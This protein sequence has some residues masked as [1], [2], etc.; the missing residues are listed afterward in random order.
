MATTSNQHY[1]LVSA[2]R[3]SKGRYPSGNETY[4]QVA[5]WLL[6]MSIVVAYQWFSQAYTLPFGG[7]SDEPAHYVTSLMVRDYIR[8]G[9]PQSPLA[10]A[11]QFYVH[12]PAVAFGMWGPML[13]VIGGAWMAIFSA[14][15]L[16]IMLLIATLSATFAWSAQWVSRRTFGSLAGLLVGLGVCLIP[17]FQA[18]STM[19]MADILTGTFM[20][21]AAY[22]WSRYLENGRLSTS[23]GFGVLAGLALL[24]KANAGALALMPLPATLL[25]RRSDLLRRRSFWIPPGIVAVLAGPW[26]I[27]YASL[28]AH[29]TRVPTTPS[30]VYRYLLHSFGIFGVLT[31]PFVLA[32]MGGL[33][34]G[35]G[36]APGGRPLWAVSVS[37]LLGFILYHCLVP[38]GFESRYVLMIAPWVAV[39][40]ISGAALSGLRLPVFIRSGFP[41]VLLASVVV[42]GAATIRIPVKTQLPYSQV[43]A[44][45]VGRTNLPQSVF[46]FS[47]E[48]AVETAFVA[49]VA[50]RDKRP[51]HFVLRGSKML[52][53][54]NWNG[55]RYENRA[56]DETQV[57]ERLGA[58]G[59]SRVIIDTTPGATPWPHHRLLR[60]AVS[61]APEWRLTR[62]Y[63]SSVEVYEFLGTAK[64][65]DRIEV[66]VPYTLRR[67]LT[68][69]VMRRP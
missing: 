9:F 11:E 55:N 42:Y 50:M 64:L 59:V 30:I 35:K 32:G 14:S 39:L 52:A 48:S 40:L 27:F 19:V 18:Y 6:Y 23:V 36:G 41:V 16:S 47:S 43:A 34:F 10:F 15:R 4:R 68:A 51:N 63:G 12:Y 20:L 26:L 61:E 37:M 38:G 62:R 46:L 5:L 69:P 17:A 67:S 66:D 7:D 21:W 8:T 13:H 60:K 58:W 22:W 1:P 28:M 3:P 31:I 45:L 65:P 54:M 49:E 33:L 44:D 29:V 24:T 53:R 2:I 25:A 56:G 57:R